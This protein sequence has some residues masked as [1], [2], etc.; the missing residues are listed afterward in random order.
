MK[1][2]DICRQLALEQYGVISR[3]QAL[4]A[5][6]SV[7]EV[8][9]R[10]ATGEWSRMHRGSYR[11]GPAP[12][13]FRQ[14]VMAACCSVPGAI[15]FRRTAAAVY[16]LHGCPPR[17]VELLTL[18]TRKASIGFDI[19]VHR[20]NYLP[21][22]DVILFHSMPMTTPARTL[23]DLGGVMDVGALRRVVIDAVQ[24][25]LVEPAQLLD[26]LERCAKPGRP[27]S[28]TLREALGEIDFEKPLSDS[29]LE[30]IAFDLIMGDG[31]PPP[32]RQFDAVGGGVLLGRVD[33][34]YPKKLLGIE[35]QG[36]EFH[37]SKPDF[38]RD[39]QRHNSLVAWG[40]RILF[41]T[42]EDSMRPRRWRDDF[43]RSY[44][45]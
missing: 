34:S 12:D 9:R 45:L 35:A 11:I 16:G 1:V 43:R 10:L 6:L 22:S 40:W 39:A 18:S 27:G 33:L 42:Y 32:R 28:R 3:S 7:K 8:E 24:K 41:F 37:T 31:Y 13:S 14:R 36:H 23:L 5:G 29:D 19:K 25:K 2:D 17:Q 30:D 20:T 21:D 38:Y 44:E 26:Q 4:E 15:A